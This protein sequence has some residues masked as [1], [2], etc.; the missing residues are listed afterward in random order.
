MLYQEI[1]NKDALKI[2]RSWKRYRHLKI[3]KQAYMLH[4][5]ECKIH[6]CITNYNKKQLLFG[7]QHYRKIVSEIKLAIASKKQIPLTPIKPNNSKRN[8]RKTTPCSSKSILNNT[9]NRSAISSKNSLNRTGDYYDSLHAFSNKE[10]KPI[11]KAK[12]KSKSISSTNKYDCDQHF[13]VGYSQKKTRTRVICKDK[14]SPH[15]FSFSL[16]SKYVDVGIMTDTHQENN[17]II[18]LHQRYML[19]ARLSKIDEEA[20]STSYSPEKPS[21]KPLCII[22]TNS[23]YK[24][25]EQCI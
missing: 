23:P 25:R 9:N 1:H 12:G 22:D 11:I 24:I 20:K 8:W 10:L 6:K 4:I 17:K 14:T 21:S 13:K 2:Q 16:I 3:L 7:L 5:K 18:K 15:N 19:K